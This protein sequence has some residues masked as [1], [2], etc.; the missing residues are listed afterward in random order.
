MTHYARAETPP[1]F[2]TS[3]SKAKAAEATKLLAL[4]SDVRLLYLSP[5]APTPRLRLRR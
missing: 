2:A 5:S 4:R 1:F 3:D